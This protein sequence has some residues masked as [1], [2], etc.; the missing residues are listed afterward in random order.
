[1]SLRSFVRKPLVLPA[2]I[3]IVVL[4]VAGAAQWRKAAADPQAVFWG[5]V[6]Q[7]LA[8]SSVTVQAAQ[9]NSATSVSQVVQYATGVNPISHSVT[10]LAQSNARVVDEMIGTPTADYT[11][12][13]SVE[14]NALTPSGK[15][16]DFSKVLGVWAKSNAG[17]GLPGNDGSVQFAQSVL[18]TGLPLGGVAIPIANLPTAQR[19]KLVNNIRSANVYQV[20]FGTIKKTSERGRQLYTYDVTIQPIL[21]ATMMKTFAQA[22]G[23]HDLDQLDPNTFSG[24]DK[25]Q[26]QLTVDV[27]ARHLV[28][29]A[30]PAGHITQQYGSYDAAV[31]T[32]LPA[33][34]VTGAELQNRL[35]HIQQ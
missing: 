27:G 32:T 3:I 20:N 26:L 13:V 33:H 15:Q 31:T 7:S 21:Y 19:S 24:Q 18:G 23:I 35:T 30:I 29:A 9:Q 6:N 17:T 14:T 16:L 28:T 10:T 12:Y 11:R 25:L 4:I 2:F 34:T 22:V 1:M 8:T 5:M